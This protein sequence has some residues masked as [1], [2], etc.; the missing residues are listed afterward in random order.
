MVNWTHFDPARFDLEFNERKL[1]AHDVSIDEAA[2][3]LWNGFLPLRDKERDDR[4]RLLGRTDAGRP[5]ELIALVLGKRR[6]R[7]IMGWPL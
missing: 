7:I 5:L 3:V 6:L 2:E 1:A 4:Y